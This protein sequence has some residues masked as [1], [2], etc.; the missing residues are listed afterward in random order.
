[1]TTST[2]SWTASTLRRLYPRLCG[3]TFSTAEV[4]R[5]VSRL[6]M[7]E[8]KCGSIDELFMRFYNEITGQDL[9]ESQMALLEEALS[10][11]GGDVE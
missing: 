4:D 7:E 5:P 6:S 9:T 8:V 2:S 1:M 10:R 11:D 3:L